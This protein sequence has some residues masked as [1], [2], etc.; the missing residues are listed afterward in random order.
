[1]STEIDV[2]AVANQGAWV[3]AACGNWD[4]V[5]LILTEYGEYFPVHSNELR[6][7]LLLAYDEF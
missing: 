6:A 4:R 7:A 1:M 5:R 3:A 2:H